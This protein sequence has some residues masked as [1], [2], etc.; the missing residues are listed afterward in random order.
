M[1]EDRDGLIWF[2]TD[3]GVFRF[4]PEKAGTGNAAT[5]NYTK[6]TGL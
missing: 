5:V 1:A 4:D 6:M 2:G 3:Q